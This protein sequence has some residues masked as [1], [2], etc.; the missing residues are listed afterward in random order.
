MYS[1]KDIKKIIRG[2]FSPHWYRVL[3]IEMLK[4]Q[5]DKFYISILRKKYWIEG[6][7]DDEGEAKFNVYRIRKTKKRLK[8]KFIYQNSHTF[9]SLKNAQ[10][11]IFKVTERKLNIDS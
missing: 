11:F 5:T 9:D 8:R 6:F 3:R 10:N 4:R 7:I 2:L 1:T